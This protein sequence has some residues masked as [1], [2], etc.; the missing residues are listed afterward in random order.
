MSKV[1]WKKLT[2]LIPNKIQISKNLYYNI[3]WEKSDE[4]QDYVGQ[5]FY[6]KNIVTLVQ[7]SNNIELTKTYL[8]EV[9]HA[10]SGEYELNLTENQVKKLESALYFLLKPGNIFKEGK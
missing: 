3:Y 9:A 1:N 10:F 5:T 7:T 8:H 4:C 2:T 6:N